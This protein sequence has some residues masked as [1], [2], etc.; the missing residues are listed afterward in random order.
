MHLQR[1]T[2][3]VF[4]LG[5]KSNAAT[6]QRKLCVRRLSHGNILQLAADRQLKCPLTTD[7][8]SSSVNK[9]PAN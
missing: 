9:C 8:L 2:E 5:S 6:K 1:F 4:Y 3:R 7:D